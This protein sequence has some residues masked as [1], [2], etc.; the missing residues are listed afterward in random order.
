MKCYTG[1]EKWTNSLEQPRQWKM[2]MRSGAWNVNE[3]LV[4]H[5]NWK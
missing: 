1:L 2:D 4:G 3:V 5:V